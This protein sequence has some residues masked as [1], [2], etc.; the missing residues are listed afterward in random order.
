[1]K[2]SSEGKADK[3]EIPQAPEKSPAESRR[4]NFLL[5]LPALVL[6]VTILG[7]NLWR[8]GGGPAASYP[9]GIPPHPEIEERFG[10]RFTGLYMASKGGMID[11]RYRVV[12]VGKAKIFGHYTETSPMIITQDAGKP[13]E[14]TVMMLHN[15]RVEGGRMYYI[16]FRNTDNA[17]QPG[18]KVTIV[19]D[20]VRLENVVVQ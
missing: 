9:N 20:D 3:M 10:V 4:R 6:F 14:V 12:D 19:I 7:F 8:V 13:I 18:S 16:L 5:L 11:M 2:G 1:M 15:H 17:V